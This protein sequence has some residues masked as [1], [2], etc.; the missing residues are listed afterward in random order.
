[1]IGDP[2]AVITAHSQPDEAGHSSVSW[3][4]ESPPGDEVVRITAVRAEGHESKGGDY[5][6]LQQ[7]I[8]LTVD[9]TVLADEA[10][11]LNPAFAVKNA[12]GTTVFT[13][14]NYEEPA[15]GS[16]RYE[17]G[18]YRARCTLPAH[19][20]NDGHYPVDVLLLD[21]TEVARASAETAVLLDVYD[22]GT[23]RGGFI[24]RCVGVVRPGAN[25]SQPPANENREPA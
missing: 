25:G 8:T 9:F 2:S 10:V 20:L 23:T 18:C 6:A 7:S 4:I 11:R 24:G 12:P 14:G 15:W 21:E 17:K 16:V 22:D 19:L 3:E 13:T 1:M 5:F